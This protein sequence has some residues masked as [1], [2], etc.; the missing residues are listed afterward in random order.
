M[1]EVE[2]DKTGKRVIIHSH[3]IIYGN[4]SNEDYRKAIQEEIEMMWN[5]PEAIVFVRNQPYKVVFNISSELNTALNSL[6]I[7][8]NT[9]GRNNYF[10]IEDNSAINISFVDGIGCNSGYFFTENLYKGSTTAAHEYGHTLGLDHPADLDIRGKGQPGI[11]YPRGT[12]TDPE[13]QYDPQIPAGE[14]GGTLHPMY[15]RVSQADI[16][17]LK[18][19]TLVFKNE[20]AHLGEFTNIYHDDHRNAV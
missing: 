20:I 11:M 19:H 8:V 15:R 12:L 5:E 3:I 4:A 14:K 1:G 13:F 16:D 7:Y 10:R 2:L 17:L 18:L 9:N 6:D